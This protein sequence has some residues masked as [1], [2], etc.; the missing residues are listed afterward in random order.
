VAAAGKDVLTKHVAILVVLAALLAG[1][2]TKQSTNV[3]SDSVDKTSAAGSSRFAIWYGGKQVMTGAFDYQGGVGVLAEHRGQPE[4]LFTKDGAFIKPAGD[5]T[6][7]L[8]VYGAV[9][10][11]TGKKW[12]Q[13]S[14]GT[15]SF[16]AVTPFGDPNELLRLVRAASDVE[17][18]ESGIERGTKVTRYRAR[19]DVE[20]ALNKFPEGERDQLRATVRQYWTDGAQAGIPIELAV[21]AENRLRSMSFVVPDGQRVLIEL[22]DYGVDPGAAT[23]QKEDVMSNDEFIARAKSFCTKSGYARGE[24]A[25]AACMIGT[26]LESK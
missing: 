23:P 18:A 20:R 15:H 1:C 25:A 26:M 2:G 19:L 12:I 21:D 8:D 13:E 3:V 6:G 10:A 9:L 16:G 24:S 5:A 14:T 7:S 11:G 4:L 22:F 17:Q